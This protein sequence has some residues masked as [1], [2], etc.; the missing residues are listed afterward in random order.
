MSVIP[1]LCFTCGFERAL[2][3]EQPSND[4]GLQRCELILNRLT[5]TRLFVARQVS[6]VISC[7]RYIPLMS[8]SL[9][10]ETFF[11]LSMLPFNDPYCKH[12][13]HDYCLNECVLSHYRQS[14]IV[15]IC[16]SELWVLSKSNKELGSR[17]LDVPAAHI[18]RSFIF[19]QEYEKIHLF[20]MLGYEEIMR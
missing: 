1:S 5:M 4:T 14:H 20:G 16:S 11:Q 19:L 18:S 7:A 8:R 13:P 6:E 10:S 3:C 12:A 15:W 2:T 17:K 9:V